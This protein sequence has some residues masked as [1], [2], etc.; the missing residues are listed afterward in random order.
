MQKNLYILVFLLFTLQLWAQYPPAAGQIG[1]TAISKDTN[2]FI[3][4]ANSC[5]ISRG[6]INISDSSFEDPD[7]PGTNR[8]SYGNASDACGIA[9]NN[10][11][12][13]GDHGMAVLSFAHP[14]ANG[15]GF[16]FVVFENSFDDN[17]LELAFVEVSSDGI[18][19][20]RFPSVSLTQT[21][22]QIQSFGTLDATK[23]HNLAGKYRVL[24][25]TPFD[26][27]ELQDSSAIDIMHITHIRI[28]DVIGSIAEAYSTHDSQGHIVNDPF[29]TP[30]WTS[31]F[32]L[33]AVGVINNS[34]N[35]GIEVNNPSKTEI[36]IFPNPAI[37]YI[38]IQGLSS[39]VNY[40]QITD[41]YGKIVKQSN[42]SSSSKINLEN[43]SKGL[44]CILLYE[45]N[46]LLKSIKFL[47]K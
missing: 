32:D 31:G 19:F 1:S 17:Y 13:L 18:H 47:K 10:A 20:V 12:S 2:I 7:N 41:A 26:L 22:T 5:S 39:T 36:T 29:P 14:I 24:Y 21:N 35:T 30:F 43:I 15:P 9:D 45:N 37:D 44:Y 4:W 23:L 11:V 46:K 8:A 3:E 27:S 33:D 42:F 38:T 40:I 28:V 25:G 34:I 6:Y 16:D